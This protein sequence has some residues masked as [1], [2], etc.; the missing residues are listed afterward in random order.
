[1]ISGASDD[2]DVYLR[3]GP[4]TRSLRLLLHLKLLLSSS[5]LLHYKYVIIWIFRYVI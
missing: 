1:M 5:T 4:T 3:T 2:D